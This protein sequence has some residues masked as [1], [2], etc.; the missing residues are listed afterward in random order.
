[1][2]ILRQSIAVLM[3]GICVNTS[4]A[5]QTLKIEEGSVFAI[6]ISKRELTRITGKNAKLKS[7]W[8]ANN[9]F[10]SSV[11]AESGDIFIKAN[12]DSPASFSF[13]VKDEAG[14]TVTLVATQQDIPSETIILDGKKPVKT[15]KAD[16]SNND[17]DGRKIAIRNLLKA[18]RN[19]D[20]YAYSV[21]PINM[22]IPLWEEVK[23]TAE[24]A[25]D[26]GQFVGTT[27]LLKN[28]SREN[29]FLEEEEFLDFG[30]SV[31]AISIEHAVVKPNEFTHVY[32][33]RRL[34]LN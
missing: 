16:P 1:M 28:T 18:M 4:F 14:I 26:T 9:V 7:V 20:E 17:G 34:T 25:Y 10:E 15:I 2:K 24:R 32:I 21:T 23:L 6:T 12:S 33:A 5:A 22:E 19:G 11:D 27:Y 30:D 3:L 29:L 8:A 31:V 13:F